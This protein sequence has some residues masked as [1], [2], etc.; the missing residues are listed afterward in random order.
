MRTI[1]TILAL[2]GLSSCAT[3]GLDQTPRVTGFFGQVACCV[4][5]FENQYRTDFQCG[6]FKIERASN[7]VV[8][9]QECRYIEREEVKKGVIL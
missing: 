4:K 6:T 5:V 7:F 8:F 1:A 9:P 3:F 2:S